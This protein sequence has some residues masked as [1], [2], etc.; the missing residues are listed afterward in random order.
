M[1]RRDIIVI[2][3]SAG[4][5]EA[6]QVLLRDLPVDLQA[7]LFVVI[8]TS[9]FSPFLLPGILSRAGPLLA[10][11]TV[12]GMEIRP[13]RIYLAPPDHHLLLRPGHVHVSK[14]PRE[15]LVRPAV[16]PLF[17]TAALAYGKRVIGVIL[18]GNLND[19][20]AGLLAVKK[21]GGV[22]IVQEPDEARYPSMPASALRYVRVDHPLPLRAIAAQLVRLNQEDLGAAPQEAPVMKNMSMESKF[23]FLQM[24]D[25]LETMDS[26]G[27][28]AP[29]SC[30]ECHGP[31]WRMSEEGPVRFRCHVGHAYTAE[32]MEAGQ[33]AA[34]EENLWGVLRQLQERTALLRELVD[35][36]RNQG[37]PEEAIGWDRRISALEEDMTH[38]EKIVRNANSSKA[39]DP[40]PGATSSG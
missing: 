10:E 19:G 37:R 28:L 5:V 17:R 7:S 11:E 12:D 16:D 39:A 1:E 14:G 23:P 35:L 6:V 30:P 25:K 18:T 26:I 22:A 13:G 38:I 20:T 2:G 36:A 24:L 31:L 29:Y 27:T 32:T 8:H 3:A 33:T 34:L 9:P 15:N 40:S 4:G 21:R